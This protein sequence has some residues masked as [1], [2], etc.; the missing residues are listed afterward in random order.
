MSADA[1]LLLLLWLINAFIVVAVIFDT[2][3]GL[4]INRCG[5]GGDISVHAIRCEAMTTV[6]ATDVPHC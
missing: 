5:G 6:I 1:W 3:I 2:I 4:C